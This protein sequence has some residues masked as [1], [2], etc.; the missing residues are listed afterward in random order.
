[1]AMRDDVR[2]LAD[3]HGVPFL[4]IECDAPREII[5]ERLAA[6]DSSGA[7]D[8]DARTGLLGEFE[9]HFEPIDELPPG[10]HLRLDT[11]Q[12]HDETR[13]LLEETFES[14]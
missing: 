7:Q 1:M 8:S 3:R 11:S 5:R 4:L 6:R 13:R 9:K 10:E 14:E 2:R 12:P